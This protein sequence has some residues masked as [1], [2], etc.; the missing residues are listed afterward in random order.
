MEPAL[1]GRHTSPLLAATIVS[2]AGSAVQQIADRTTE[3]QKEIIA[4]R[5]GASTPLGKSGGAVPDPATSCH[6]Y[7]RQPGSIAVAAAS[8]KMA[9]T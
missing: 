7:L 5:L 6:P 1:T 9:C 2:A 4:R 8:A 3:L